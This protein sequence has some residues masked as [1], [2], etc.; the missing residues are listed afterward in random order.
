MESA[1]KTT[2]IRKRK[3][4]E[5]DLRKLL[6]VVL[7]SRKW[8]NQHNQFDLFVFA[9]PTGKPQGMIEKN[10]NGKKK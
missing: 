9:R 10:R 2:K 8:G 4:Q 6:F 7:T 3:L 5:S 1:R